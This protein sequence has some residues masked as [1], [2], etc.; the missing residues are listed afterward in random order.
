VESFQM[1]TLYVNH[2]TVHS[3]LYIDILKNYKH[4][5]YGALAQFFLIKLKGILKIKIHIFLS[6]RTSFLVLFLWIISDVSVSIKNIDMDAIG[7]S[8]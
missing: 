1:N 8:P 4:R 5:N 3:K 2:D 6:T 7:I